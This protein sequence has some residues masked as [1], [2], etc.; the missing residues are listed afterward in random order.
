MTT[1]IILGWILS[2][3]KTD[4]KDWRRILKNKKILYKSE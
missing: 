4:K 3:M 2:S 1:L